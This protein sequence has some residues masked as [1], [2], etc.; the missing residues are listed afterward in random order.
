MVRV[1]RTRLVDQVASIIEANCYEGFDRVLCGQTDAAEK[2]VDLC[3][4]SQQTGSSP[5]LVAQIT[6]I[7]CDEIEVSQAT[8]DAAGGVATISY[9]HAIDKLAS[10]LSPP[11]QGA[12]SRAAAE[13]L[14]EEFLTA[15]CGVVNKQAGALLEL[16]RLREGLV[17]R[18]CAASPPKEPA[19]DVRLHQLASPL[20][21]KW[22]DKAELMKSKCDELDD[23]E[24]LLTGI[25]ADRLLACANELYAALIR[26]QEEKA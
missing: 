10:L 3:V 25:D 23:D 2:I 14:I 26:S 21:K 20:V 15:Y 5:E 17:Q 22:Q 12:L 4:T 8:L 11:A 13:E 1:K 19:W 9:G 18:L 7:L 16:D 24:A 6:D